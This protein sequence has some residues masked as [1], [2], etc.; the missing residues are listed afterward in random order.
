MN[1]EHSRKSFI[2]GDFRL[3]A[4]MRILSENGREIHLPKRPFNVL[5][6][7]VENRQ[8]I[9]S[10]DE[11]LEKFWDGHDVYDDALRKTI[12]ALRKALN[13]LEKPP[14][15][16][17]TRYG[18]G[19]RFIGD[20]IAVEPEKEKEK[21]RI[22][23]A[24][25]QKPRYVLLTISA[26]CLISLVAFGFLAFRQKTNNV[27]AKSENPSGKKAEKHSI[28]VL[29]LKN[30]TGDAAND[31][32]SDGVTESII[33]ELSRIPELKI[34]SRSST[35]T[36]KNKEINAPEIAEKLKIESFLEGSLQKKGDLLSVNVRLINAK[37]GRI[38]W[39]SLDFERPLNQ[40]FELQDIISCNVA[41]E[42]GA[43]LCGLIAQNPRR[44]TKNSDA[45]QAYLQGRFHWNK[46]TGEGIKKS[47]EY[48]EKAVAL[49]GKFAPA[50]AGLSESYLQGIWHVPF[51]A[52]EVLP[53]AKTAALK[54]LE[55]DDTL[56][57]AHTALT[58]VYQLEWNWTE[59]EREITRAV[60]L[61]PRYARAH[62]VQAFCFLVAGRSDEAVAAI[63]RAG[64]LDPLN[65]VINTDKAMIFF[66]ANRNEE[67]FR[68]WEK[69]LELDP[70]FIMA[71]EHRAV[72]FEVVGNETAAIE[73]RAKVM[74]LYGETPEKI[75]AFRQSAAKSGLREFY[76]KKLQSELAKE[77][78]AEYVSSAFLAIYYVA[79]GEKE[80]AFKRLERAFNERSAE[81]V[82]VKTSRQF[83]P[84]RSDSRFADLFRRAGLP[85]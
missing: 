14:R 53:K 82:F 37:D 84:L 74:Q 47:I 32:L 76:R 38:L 6:Y 55:L 65:L 41:N 17:E 49:D 8:R 48:Y 13:D 81:M 64:E 1:A 31:F 20:V 67:A 70:N 24:E 5:S 51:P 29:P 45:Y 35:F 25:P 40:S 52:K 18:S 22:T 46:R 78:R 9:V 54:A 3:D 30:L 19:Y 75:T 44:Y 77:S 79:L 56:A 83:D 7:L 12:G 68:Q 42:L 28:A 59:A 72:A 34:I 4:G 60:E 50:F 57:E 2:F 21:K 16:I 69:T 63:E 43:E 10:R 27:S 39:T 15:F 66:V 80:E 58:N 26:V 62:H 23:A 85:E 11:L 73:E 33:T 36:F 71:R 61:N